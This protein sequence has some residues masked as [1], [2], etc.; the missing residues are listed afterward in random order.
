MY[1]VGSHW[2]TYTG[3][4]AACAL[5]LFLCICHRLIAHGIQNTN[6]K[7][8]RSINTSTL[9]ANA[10][11]TNITL[12]K[13]RTLSQHRMSI[14]GPWILLLRCVIGSVLLISYRSETESKKDWKCFCQ[15]PWYWIKKLQLWFQKVQINWSGFPLFY[16]VKFPDFS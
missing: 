15:L 1:I 11:R 3:W 16:P 4:K 9:F 7:E 12:H 13:K 5:L 2:V 6:A 14:T 10:L 8:C